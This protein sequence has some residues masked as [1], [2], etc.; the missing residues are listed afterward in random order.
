MKSA[1]ETA[2]LILYKTE[3]EGAY[4]NLELKSAIPEEMEQRDRAFVTSLVYG[5]INK[6]LTLDYIIEQYSKIKLKKLSKYIHQILRMGLYQMFFMDKIP[7]SAA[8][9]E[10]V[11]LARRY[12]HGA[13]AGFVNGLLRSASKGE[14]KYPT[15]KIQYLS[16]KYS[17]PVWICEKW[18]SDFGYEFTQKLM[19]AFDNE[20]ELNLRPNTLKI[21]A[22]ELAQRLQEYDAQ[23]KDNSVVCKGLNIGNDKLYKNGF[24]TVQDRAA[25][26]AV[27]EL[28][29]HKGET[30]IDI[31]AAPGGKTTYM[32]ELMKNQ[33]RILAFDIYE[34]K[35]KLIQENAQ[36]LGISIIEAKIADATKCDDSLI[37][38]ADKILCDVPCSG[39]G[40]L[41]RKPDIKWNR[42]EED[43]FSAVQ[44]C[45]LKN[46]AQYL[47]NEGQILYSTCTV[48]KAENEGIIN[49]FL[50]ENKSFEKLYE[51]TFYP[52]IDGTDGFYICKLKKND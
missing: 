17:F 37:A 30:V 36:R 24:Y 25:M 51:K 11:K 23:K 4:P 31:C 29:P 8:V 18:I 43:D 16:V 50:E 15:D 28:N 38:S 39:W 2:L 10:S 33:G 19:S 35:I 49:A 26:A 52:H 22:D 20:P 5:V 14:I 41:R 32:A 7:Q 21:T 47:K 13:S 1:R 12:G 48:N 40:I 9:N 3:Y 42:T 34:H 6:K 27:E 44:M 46:A 45:I